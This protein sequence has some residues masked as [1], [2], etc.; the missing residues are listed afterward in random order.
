MPRDAAPLTPQQPPRL[1]DQVSAVLRL[2]HY[3]LRTERA[4]LGWIRRFILFHDK[5]HPA[6]MG[7][8]E[9]VAFLSYLATEGQVSAPTQNQALAA[10][11][12]LYREILKRELD[13]LDDAVRAH[14]PRRLPVVLTRDEVRAVLGAL[15]GVGP[16]YGLMGTLLYGGGLRLMDCLRLRVR[17]IDFGRRQLMLRSGKG[18]GDRAAILPR[19]AERALREQLALVSALHQR[20][21]AGG[22]GRVRLPYAYARKA[23]GAAGLFSW[24]WAFPASRLSADPRTG[25]LHRH[26]AHPSGLQRAVRDAGLRARLEKRVTCHV[27]RHSFATHLLEGGS[28]IR[29]VQELLGHRDVKTT[30]IYT[31]VLDRGP[32]GVTSPAD[33][34]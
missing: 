13:D 14:Q 27:L 4:Y 11:L 24:Q 22:H 23:L 7:A 26:H 18:G 32:A 2:R 21:L 34:L 15:H 25:A 1:L 19:T 12:F 30:M 8:P 3:S 33:R 28:D 5:R 20:D 9:V 17:D 6:S 10:L 31:H 29:T 16:C